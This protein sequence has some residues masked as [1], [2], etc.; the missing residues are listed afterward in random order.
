MNKLTVKQLLMINQKLT[1]KEIHASAVLLETLGVISKMPYEQDEGF[2]YKY[3]DTVAKAAKLGCSL[4]G[5]KPFP[6]KNNQ[7]AIVSLLSLLELNK[8]KLTD[9]E[10]DLPALVDL[11][12]A[13]NVEKTCDW[14]ENHKFQRDVFEPIP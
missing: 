7:T 10:N 13:G 1:G 9:Y 8:I 3:K 6:E 2:F 11:L 14:I 12:E 4:A 5:A